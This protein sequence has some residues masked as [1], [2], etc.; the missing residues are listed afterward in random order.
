[1]PKL[2]PGDLHNAM[3][4]G[5]VTSATAPCATSLGPW[6]AMPDAFVDGVRGG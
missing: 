6:R 5:E 1:M 2:G 4:R 3:Q